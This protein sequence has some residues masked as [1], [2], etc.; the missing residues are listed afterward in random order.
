MTTPEKWTPPPP[1]DLSPQE[2]HGCAVWSIRAYGL[3]LVPVGGGYRIGQSAHA[4][5]RLTT[6]ALDD[7]IRSYR[8]EVAALLQARVQTMVTGTCV[9]TPAD[10]DPWRHAEE[11]QARM[12]V[13]ESKIMQWEA[14]G[15]VPRV[16]WEPSVA[17]VDART[18]QPLEVKS[19]MLPE[20]LYLLRERTPAQPPTSASSVAPGG[21]GGAQRGGAA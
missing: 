14:E 7:E 20:A 16:R 13:A 3:I 1:P 4:R 12:A 9:P 6:M 11:G 17:I 5:L 8:D 21:P 15:C 19:W 18:G 2:A 10:L